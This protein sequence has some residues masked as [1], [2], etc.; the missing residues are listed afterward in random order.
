[1]FWKYVNTDRFQNTCFK[2]R[3]SMAVGKALGVMINVCK[4]QFLLVVT[5]NKK[6]STKQVISMTY[7]L[8]KRFFAAATFEELH[9]FQ[10]KSKNCSILWPLWVFFIFLEMRRASKYSLWK[11]NLFFY[12]YVFSIICLSQYLFRKIVI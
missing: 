4:K 12:M 8:E 2:E 7:K 6:H 1:M 5:W 9:S 3:N 10:R 11:A